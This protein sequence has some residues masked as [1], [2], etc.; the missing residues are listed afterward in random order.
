MYEL[1][2]LYWP[3]VPSII[4]VASIIAKITPNKTD[5][6]VIAAVLKVVDKLAFTTGKTELLNKIDWK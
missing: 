3:V 6:K 1:I 4:A 5:D 2:C